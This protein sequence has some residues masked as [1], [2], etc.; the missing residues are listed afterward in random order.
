MDHLL[1][2]GQIRAELE[3]LESKASAQLRIIEG[4]WGSVDD[5]RA[6]IAYD[7]DA[8]QYLRDLTRYCRQASELRTIIDRRKQLVDQ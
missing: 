4:R 3:G 7:E 8:R 6:A 1:T 5:A 2:N